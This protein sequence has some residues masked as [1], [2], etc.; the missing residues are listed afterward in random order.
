MPPNPQS[1]LQKKLRCR[2]ALDRMIVFRPTNC[3]A[4]QLF[5]IYIIVIDYY[6]CSKLQYPLCSDFIKSILNNSM[7]LLH[8]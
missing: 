2:L 5:T 7:T 6:K 4:L 1:L 8:E 3:N